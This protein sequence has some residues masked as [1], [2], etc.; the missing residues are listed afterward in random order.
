MPRTALKR[1]TSEGARDEG[2]VTTL[3]S[4]RVIIQVRRPRS[5]PGCP[6]SAQVAS[7]KRSPLKRQEPAV[8]PLDVV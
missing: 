1:M 3:L 5:K 2:L 8:N 7:D 6:M 4:L